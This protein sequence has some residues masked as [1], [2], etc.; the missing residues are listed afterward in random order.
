MGEGKSAVAARSTPGAAFIRSAPP[1]ILAALPERMLKANFGK[2]AIW[3][4]IR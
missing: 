4:T 3:D 1:Q 2:S